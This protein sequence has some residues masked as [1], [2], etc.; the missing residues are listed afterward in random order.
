MSKIKKT[1]V[2]LLLSYFIFSFL[3]AQESYIVKGNSIGDIEV[4]YIANEGFLIS[5][6]AT[7]I[8]IDALFVRND[9]IYATPDKDILDNMEKGE[10]PFDN[11]DIIMVTHNHSDHFTPDHVAR[12]LKNNP[13]TVLVTTPQAVG[14][15]KNCGDFTENISDRLITCDLEIGKSISKS[16]KGLDI[17]I[18]RTP[19]SGTNNET[20]NFIYLINLD[21]RKILHEGDARRDVKTFENLN[22]EN[23]NIDIAFGHTWYLFDPA[24]REVLTKHF[25][26]KQ[27]VLM[28]ISNNSFEAVID[29][30]EDF[31]IYFNNVNVFKKKLDKKVFE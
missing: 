3:Y 10:P 11:V 30:F 27:F 18:F 29:R 13:E 6:G 31:K 2:L 23:E 26:P 28:H 19:H 15:I 4:T 22:L 5:S 21:G 12:A 14:D 16:V 17:K 20:Q 25:K 9:G 8:L 1:A 24:G 7:K